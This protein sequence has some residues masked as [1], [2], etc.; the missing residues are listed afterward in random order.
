MFGIDVKMM[1]SVVNVGK[2]GDIL[3][4]E[5]D[6]DEIEGVESD[7]DEVILLVKFGISFM[8]VGKELEVI[9]FEVWL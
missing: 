4:E 2:N 3:S 9:D 8:D 7:E 5:R 6:Q 1:D